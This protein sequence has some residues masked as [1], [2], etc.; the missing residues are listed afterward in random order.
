MPRLCS[1]KKSKKSKGR[2]GRNQESRERAKKTP[3][4]PHN[5]IKCSD[6][7]EECSLVYD[8]QS[9]DTICE[10]SG[11]VVCMQG[12]GAS[13]MITH[14]KPI[15]PGYK[16][17][18]H[19][20]QRLAQL[21]GN[22][23]Q[24]S[25]KQIGQIFWEMNFSAGNVDLAGK[26]TFREVIKSLG[27]KSKLGENW[28]QIRMKLFLLPVPNKLMMDP[29]LKERLRMR[30]LC[31]ENAFMMTLYVPKRGKGTNQLKRK[32][33]I[34]INYVIAQLLRLENEEAFLH[35]LQFLPQLAG[36]GQPLK[37]NIRWEI[38]IDYCKIHYQRFSEP[39]HEKIFYFH[40]EYLPITEES[41]ELFNKF[42]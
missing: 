14:T 26:K 10:N 6:C 22:G 29:D 15:S 12:F 13:S 3:K 19:F 24:L 23:P 35:F 25:N 18:T 28:I 7:K 31:I 39:K 36:T 4:A 5:E 32:S 9:G 42:I 8:H 20:Q 21:V 2:Q 27:M 17:L 37:N 34:N 38:L 41:L 40:W 33:I 16:R 30:Y 1:K 11:I